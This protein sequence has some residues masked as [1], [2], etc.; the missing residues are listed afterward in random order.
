[1]VGAARMKTVM[2]SAWPVSERMSRPGVLARRLALLAL[3]ALA[4]LAAACGQS[5]RLSRS[6]LL[7]GAP[8]GSSAAMEQALA[9]QNQQLAALRQQRVL[10][11]TV[12]W[13]LSQ[14][15]LD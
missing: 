13:Y 12:N 14:M 15:S 6:D 9:A 10:D 1:M 8:A 4:L 7:I 11:D 3:A 2:R 5:T